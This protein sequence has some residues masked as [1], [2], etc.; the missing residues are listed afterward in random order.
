MD[1]PEELVIN[2]IARLPMK[3][4]ARFKSVYREWKPFTESKYFRHLY[5]S[6]TSSTSC[7]NWSILRRDVGSR[8]SGLEEV[9]LDLPRESRHGNTSF[10]S[11]FTLNTKNI[12]I[13]EIRVAACTD[14]LVLLR[15]ELD[16][17]T[18]RYDIGNPV[19]QQWI[20]L[21]PPPIPRGSSHYN[22]NDSGLVTRMHNHT[23]LGYKVVLIHREFRSFPTYRFF[24]F[25]SDT[26]E[27]SLQV[28][29]CPGPSTN[30]TSRTSNPVSLNGKLHWLDL[31]GHITVHDFFSN[32]D[33]VRAISLP[34]KMQGSPRPSGMMV[35]TTSQGSFV[36]IDVEFMED[37]TKS[38]N[39]RI[40]RLKCDSWSWEK[41]WDI[42]LACVGLGRSCVPMAINVFDIDIIYLWDFHN[43][44]FLACNLRT[45][46][47]SYGARKDGYAI[48]FERWWCLSQFVPSLQ[49]VPTL[50]P[51]LI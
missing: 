23:L 46:T 8:R 43:K 7:S 18:I 28:H 38:Y 49:V 50:E 14:G 17:M 37:V 12:K 33:Q 31:S 36:L 44:C 5:H 26:V 40:W 11:C 15:L 29:S 10:A 6:N 41:A 25:S 48:F 16:D 22:Y 9:K 24:I 21:P 32:D 1:L 19:L 27:W 45:N 34:A 4:L 47:K 39:V 51:K 13:K 42:N 30:V 3:S 35:Y 2:I 20:Q